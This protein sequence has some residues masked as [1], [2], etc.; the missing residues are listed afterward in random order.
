MH[1]DSADTYIILSVY[2]TFHLHVVDLDSHTALLQLYTVCRRITKVI[3]DCRLGI[4]KQ[5]H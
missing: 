4:E 2:R 1:P 5:F 3:V